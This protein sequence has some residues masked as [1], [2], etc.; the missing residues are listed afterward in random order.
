[1]S[2]REGKK[3]FY[4]PSR[5]VAET[6][7]PSHLVS[8][9]GTAA[10]SY[11]SVVPEPFADSH[12]RPISLDQLEKGMVPV[13]HAVEIEEIEADGDPNKVLPIIYRFRSAFM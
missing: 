11:P 4:S 13:L 7:S 8:A 6:A 3:N 9:D 2:C 5:S 12:H 10:P 1:M